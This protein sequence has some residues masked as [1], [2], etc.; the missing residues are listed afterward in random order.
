[1]PL[2]QP[3]HLL[4]PYTGIANRYKTETYNLIAV[5]GAFIAGS[6]GFVFSIHVPCP[7][8]LSNLIG[9]EHIQDRDRPGGPCSGNRTDRTTCLVSVHT[10]PCT[11]H[12]R[13]SPQPMKGRP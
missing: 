7:V 9:P 11:K 4:H 6:F 13:L 10:A 1:M 8:L 12:A 2:W 3:L 5:P